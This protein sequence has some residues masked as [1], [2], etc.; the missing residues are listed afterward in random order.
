M[1]ERLVQFRQNGRTVLR[2]ITRNRHQGRFELTLNE[3]ETLNTVFD[4][5]P[6]LANN[7][8]ITASLSDTKGFTASASVSGGKVTVT[9]SGLK[10][11]CP[12]RTDMT[13][14]RS[15]GQTHVIKIL[16]RPVRAFV[17][18]LDYGRVS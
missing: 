18:T 10:G 6:L 2:G 11:N 1:T 8:T 4:F 7:E 5:S 12:G 14:T 17:E 13:I 16:A 15:A 3:G 9:A